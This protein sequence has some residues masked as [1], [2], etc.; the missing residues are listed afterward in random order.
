MWIFQWGAFG[1]QL[2]G[3]GWGGGFCVGGGGGGWGGGGVFGVSVAT[4]GQRQG[5]KERPMVVRV[6]GG[7][8]EGH[9]G[10]WREGKCV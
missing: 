4:D 1:L 6:P 8:S 5:V 10:S 9:M 3:G 7:S 2:G